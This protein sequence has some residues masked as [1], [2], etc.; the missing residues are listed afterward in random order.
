M[1]E[2]L[3]LVNLGA[4]LAKAAALVA[5]MAALLEAYKEAGMPSEA[6]GCKQTLNAALAALDGYVSILRRKANAPEES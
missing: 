3:T 2:E 6:E 5:P 1:P 4:E